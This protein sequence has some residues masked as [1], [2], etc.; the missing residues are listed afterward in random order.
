MAVRGLLAHRFFISS[1][2]RK[3]EGRG[4]VQLEQWISQVTIYGLLIS[5]RSP[6]LER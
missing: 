4:V 6:N 1:N 3:L 2:D 5:S